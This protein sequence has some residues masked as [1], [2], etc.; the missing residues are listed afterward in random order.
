MSDASENLI[1]LNESIRRK[2]DAAGLMAQKIAHETNNYYGIIQGYIS[3]MEMQ[4]NANDKL[5]QMLIP[6]KEALHSGIQLN[7]RLAAFYGS[8]NIMGA[9]VD[10]VA[11]VKD[12][13]ATFSRAGDLAVEVTVKEE[14]PPVY[15]DEPA[16]QS[17]LRDLCLLLKV[18]GT[19]PAA[20]ILSRAQLD[21]GTIAGMVLDSQPGSYACVQATISL[22]DYDQPEATAFMNPFAFDTGD[23]M[24]LGLALIYGILRNHE[25]NLDVSVDHAQLALRLYFPF[26]R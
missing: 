25:G 20:L 2:F 10:L 18:T 3:L 9:D 26:Q 13:C 17:L 4:L 8:T 7:K 16:V 23:P 21:E 24:S 1:S 11:A 15:L 22:S 12:A 14:L 19:S 6:I 5:A